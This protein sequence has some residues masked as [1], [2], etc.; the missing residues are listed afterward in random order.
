MKFFDLE[1]ELTF[2]KYNGKTLEDIVRI[3]PEYISVVAIEDKHFFI[4]Q[5]VVND[6]IQIAPNFNIS[7][8]A[9][10]QLAL[11]HKKWMKEAG[12]EEDEEEEAYAYFD[13]DS[14]KAEFGLPYYNENEDT[15]SLEAAALESEVT[16]ELTNLPSALNNEDNL[17]KV[18]I[19][20]SDIDDA[21]DALDDF[22][23]EGLVDD[24]DAEDDYSEDED[25]W[26]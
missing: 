22:P 18:V 2:G 6:L 4:S 20:K 13:E 24:Y 3:D 26:D 5:V 19:S 16:G 12:I 7:S 8:Y 1:S 21:E 10:E 15:L 23:Y 11:K 17:R 9:Q 14:W 25:E